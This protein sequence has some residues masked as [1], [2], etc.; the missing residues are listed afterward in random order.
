MNHCRVYQKNKIQEPIEDILRRMGE[1]IFDQLLNFSNKIFD[2]NNE[3]MGNYFIKYDRS[4]GGLCFLLNKKKR[5]NAA[6]LSTVKYSLEN[7]LVDYETVT[8]MKKLFTVK[9]IWKYSI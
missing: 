5:L 2:L 9:I 7:T 4:Y 6:S 3:S 1:Y 8:F